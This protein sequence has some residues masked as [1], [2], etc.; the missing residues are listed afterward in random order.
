MPQDFLNTFQKGLNKDYSL[1]L[2]PD[3][4]YRHCV[5]CDLISQDGNDYTIKDCLGN[6]HVFTINPPYNGVYTVVGALPMPILFISFPNRL[7][8]LSTNSETGGYGEIGEIKYLPYGEGIQPDSVSGEYNAGYVPLYHYAGFNFSKEHRAE[9]F[10]YEENELISRIYWTDNNNEPRVFN[11]SDPI[12]TDYKLTGDLIVGERYMVLEGAI[13]HNGVNYGPGL[14]DGNV[15]LAVNANFV[16]LTTPTPSPK[17]VVYYPVELLNFTPSRALGTIT[18]DEYGTG[19]LVCGNKIYFY[20]LGKDNGVF[21]TWSYGSSPV[22]VG[23]QNNYV[24]ITTYHNFVGN[25]G[26]N[27]TAN[28][29]L[30]VFVN[31]DNIDTDFDF[32]ELA[33]AEFDQSIDVPRQITIVARQDINGT[34]INIQHDGNSS[35]GALT[36]GDVT[37]FPASIL[38][39]KTISTNKNYILAGN[40]TERQEF[41]F[42]TSGITISQFTYPMNSHMDADSCALSGMKYFGVSPNPGVNPAA[43]TIT[44]YSRW[45]VTNGESAVNTVTY[46][47]TVYLTGQVIVGITGAGNDTITFAG[48]GAVRPCVTRNKYDN[49]TTGDR[50]ES[51]IELKA[52]T[53]AANTAFWDYKSAAVHHHA[54]GYWSNETYRLGLLFFDLKGVPFYVKHLGDFTLDSAQDSGGIIQSDVIGNTGNL[55]YSLKAFGLNISNIVISTD[56]ADIISG[57]SIVRAERQAKI[58]CQ[59]IVTQ[60]VHTGASPDVYQVGAW[61]PVSLS[62]T[63]VLGT[64]Y[65][66]ISPDLLVDVPLKGTVGDIGDT[67]VSASWVD[68]YDYGGGLRQRGETGNPAGSDQVYAKML[69]NLTADTDIRTGVL[70]YWNEVAEGQSLNDFSGGASLNNDMTTAAAGVNVEGACVTGGVDYALNAY[71]APGGKKVIFQLDADFLHYGPSANNYTSVAA[72]AQTEKLIMNYTK[73]GS[74]SPYGSLE[75]TLYVST[76]HFQPMS[77]QVK[78]DTFNGSDGY[79]FN[80]VEIFGGDCFTCLIDYGYGLWN[81]AAVNKYSYAWTFPCQCNSNYNL[82]RGRKTSTVAMWFTGSAPTSDA[83]VYLSPAPDSLVQLEDFS[84]NPGYS[85]GGQSGTGLPLIVY[86][87]LPANFINSGH[88]PARIRYAGEKFI[89][90]ITDSFRNFAIND[91]KDLS[92]Q[93]GRINNIK[94]KEDKVVVWQDLAVN[95]V[96]IL[97]R[98]LLGAPTGDA[99]TI[100]TGGVVDR[101]DILTSYFGNQHQ[102]GLI[103]TEYGFAWFDM[104]RKGF[105]VLGLDGSGLTEPSLVLGL[106]GFF[107]EVFLESIGVNYIDRDD[108]LNS[109]TFNEGSDRPLMGVGITGVY[110]PKLKMTYMT[111]KFKARKLI[112]GFD[113]YISKDFTIGYLHNSIDK[114]FIGFYDTFPAISHN[115]NLWVL[116]ANNPKNTTQFLTASAVNATFAIGETFYSGNSEYICIAPVT[117]DNAAKYPT[118]AS[119]ATYWGLIN[120]TNQLWVNNQPISLNQGEAPGY[121]YNKFFGRVVNNDFTFIINPVKFQDQSFNVFAIEQM[122]PFN[123]NY[124]D[125]YIEAGNQSAADNNITSTNRNYRFIWDKICSNLPVSSTGRIVNRYLQVRFYKKNYTTDPRVLTTSVKILQSVKSFFNFKR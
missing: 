20:R 89:G 117:L 45:L 123:V 2:Q 61:I 55:V 7:I 124:T 100:G 38:K 4:T 49:T 37:L 29:G 88:F 75:G 48:T 18:F 3:G 9:G 111:F 16:S 14:T 95:T 122:T 80:N 90:E 32:V 33:C 91:Y 70:T 69:T 76:G 27:F 108:F 43:G 83:I 106:Q 84:Y 98:Q 105:V 57:F 34:T 93:N 78:I 25:G 109:P 58:M 11:I 56:I 82:R 5:N 53:A 66:F 31:I 54:A 79:T 28:S 47:G 15:F 103:E 67:M 85:A 74:G 39:C 26:E 13:T 125:I 10:G 115:H 44:P 41:D 101:F 102:W 8:V 118:G 65:A 68:A 59:G 120:S 46:N 23:A 96:P 112:S 92:V 51:A 50:T 17:V 104:H 21:T 64:T 42:D 30:S 35:L 113:S 1:I 107:S 12:F 87:A 77:A 110:D 60:C 63:P 71:S 73:I 62:N 114:M 40:I 24:G 116:G 97:E 121:Q 119:G 94:V 52:A 99:T 72:N 81:E 22:P 6:T 36:I 86:P 19:N